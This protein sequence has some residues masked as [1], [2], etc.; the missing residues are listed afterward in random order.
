MSDDL[1]A[2]FLAAA[3]GDPEAQYAISLRN[4]EGIEAGTVHQL[5]G[6]LEGVAYARMAA[7]NGHPGALLLLARHIRQLSYFCAETGQHDLAADHYGHAMAMMEILT[8]HLPV[9]EADELRREIDA[10]A[11]RNPAE[12]MRAAKFYRDL[13]APLLTPEAVG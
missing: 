6:S 11:D 13:W 9:D 2:Q 4:R 12:V 8:E 5:Y 10:A 3:R 1:P 7:M